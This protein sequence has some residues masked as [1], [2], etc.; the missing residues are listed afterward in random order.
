MNPPDGASAPVSAG[1]IERM[2]RDI[3]V[4]LLPDGQSFEV[5]YRSPDPHVAQ[6]VAARLASLYIQDS[7][8]DRAIL[9]KS[10][11]AFLEAQ[12]DDVRSRLLSQADEIRS[13]VDVH[14]PDVEVQRLEHEQLNRSIAGSS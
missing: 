12:I 9:P 6:K 13:A 14:A 10:S 8:Q 5:S 7:V 11:D 4:Q 2:R 1:V 3:D